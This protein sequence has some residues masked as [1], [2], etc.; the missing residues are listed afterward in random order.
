MCK[1]AD[2]FCRGIFTLATNFGELA[3][4]MI[5]KL[6]EYTPADGKYFDLLDPDGKKV[7]V[8]FSRAKKKL[9]PLSKTNVVELCLNSTAD[10][11]RTKRR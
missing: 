2:E 4:L 1:H 8:K 11:P 10:S 3:Q 5:K 9:K 7:E 6:E